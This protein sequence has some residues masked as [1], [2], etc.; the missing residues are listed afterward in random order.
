MLQV[1]E[2]GGQPLY[3]CVFAWGSDERRA[4][5]VRCGI[6]VRRKRRIRSARRS[7]EIAYL[8]S[9]ISEAMVWVVARLRKQ[10]RRAA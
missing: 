5:C 9:E 3:Y 4:R 6:D 1:P 2:L 7:H 10:A 8:K